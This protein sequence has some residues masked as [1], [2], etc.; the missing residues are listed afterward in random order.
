MNANDPHPNAPVEE[1]VIPAEVVAWWIEQFTTSR[2][3]LEILDAAIKRWPGRRVQLDATAV[4]YGTVNANTGELRGDTQVSRRDTLSVS[5]VVGKRTTASMIAEALGIPKK[6][7]NGA[8]L[9]AFEMRAESKMT[10]I[11]ARYIAIRGH[12]FE[13]HAGHVFKRFRLI[14]IPEDAV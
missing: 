5:E 9:Q 10:T 14:D 11:E 7:E 6:L 2:P 8:H 3:Y 4:M 13:A 12:G 1:R